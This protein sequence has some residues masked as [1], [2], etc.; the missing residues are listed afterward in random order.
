MFSV[1]SH[2]SRMTS[3]TIF[4]YQAWY[5]CNTSVT[6]TY[7]KMNIG[8]NQLQIYFLTEFVFTKYENKAVCICVCMFVFNQI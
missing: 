5:I 6:Q 1:S 3:V 4:C 2:C 7:L 8:G